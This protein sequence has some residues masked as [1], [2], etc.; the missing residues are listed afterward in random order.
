MNPRRVISGSIRLFATCLDVPVIAVPVWLADESI[1]N[2]V[3]NAV[4][5]AIRIGGIRNHIASRSK[6]LA[7]IA[8]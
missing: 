8:Q 7:D 1:P 2:F 5:G 6:F 4:L 3:W